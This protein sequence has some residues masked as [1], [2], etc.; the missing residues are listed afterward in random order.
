MALIPIQAAATSYGWWTFGVDKGLFL[1][2]P[3]DLYFGWIVLWSAVPIVAF[4]NAGVLGIAAAMLAVD[5]LVMPLCAP[6]VRLGDAWYVGEFVAVGSA[7]VPAQY[8]ARWTIESRHLRAR[9]VFQVV[10]FTGLL[11]FLIPAMVF[12][13]VGGSWSVLLNRTTFWN[14]VWF[15]LLAIPAIVGLSAVQ[16]FVV[17]GG[18]T[19]VPMTLHCDW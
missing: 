14:S 16:E 13:R 15:Q 9:A 18:G 11:L 3:L 12:E 10:A 7:L 2:V 1:E 8:L 6:V 5:L 4:P 17:S 19:P